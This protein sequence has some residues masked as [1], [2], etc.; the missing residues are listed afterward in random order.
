MRAPSDA[1]LH[2]L[3]FTGLALAGAA[4]SGYRSAP[5]DDRPVRP[6]P[7]A[8]EPILEPNAVELAA[9]YAGADPAKGIPGIEILGLVEDP[10]TIDSVPKCNGG[11]CDPEWAKLAEHKG[12]RTVIFRRN[13]KTEALTQANFPELIGPIDT[14]EKAALRMQLESYHPSTSCGQL[15]AQKLSCAQG[16]DPSH[17]PVRAN[18][19]KLEVVTFSSMNVCTMNQ[20]GQAR[21]LGVMAVAPDGTL[22]HVDNALTQAAAA[23]I[24]SR[25]ECRSPSRGRMFEGFEHGEPGCSELDYLLRAAREEAAAVV[26]FERLAG[27]LASH[28]APAELVATARRSAADERRHAQLFR[29]EASRLAC[30]IGVE[31]GPVDANAPSTF[32]ERSLFAMLSENA[33]EGCANE[34]F[35]ALVATHQAEHARDTRLRRLF[36]SIARD[37]RE[38]AILAYRIHAWGKGRLAAADAVAL[39]DLLCAACDAMAVA[40]SNAVSADMGEPPPELAR[41]AFLQVV[42]AFARA[43]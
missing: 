33:T 29:R 13:G 25:V 5:P 17:V 2:Q 4:C 18:E 39:D 10:G 11:P 3:F 6:E 32:A 38:H 15:E 43:A 12:P 7:T 27:E 9:Q 41:A 20:F 23:S 1:T 16:S 35:A 34:T 30:A 37:E 36:A 14:P 28:G 26:A 21:V 19:G 22:S 42:D 31:V 24:L 40:P 8:N